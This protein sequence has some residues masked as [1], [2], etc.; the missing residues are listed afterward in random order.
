MIEKLEIVKI[1]RKQQPS[2]FKPGETYNI[3]TVLV[4]SC[5]KGD[6]QKLTAM[7]AWADGWKVGDV[8]EGEIKEKK[9]TD[10]DGFEQVNFSIENPNKK[11]FTPG[12]SS[13]FNPLVSAYQ[14][15]ASLAPLL[16]AGKK[17]VKLD[18]IDKLANAI[19]DRIGSQ[20]A[21]TND[22]KPAEEKVKKIDVDDEQELKK[23]TEITDEDDDSF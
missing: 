18:D 19:K 3:A 6:N 9:W 23:D 16:F 14:I 13:F 5:S 11:Q 7:G 21:P 15:A 12:K 8:V 17:A 2:K 22:S 20:A 1:G 10:K 4:K